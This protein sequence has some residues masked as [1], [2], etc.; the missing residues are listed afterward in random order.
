[1]KKK[2][3][4][5]VILFTNLKIVNGQQA[6]A[7]NG[8]ISDRLTV[9]I[10]VYKMLDNADKEKGDIDGS[11]YFTRRSVKSGLA[12][13]AILSANSHRQCLG[14]G[15]GFTSYNKDNAEI[16]HYFNA[17]INI[18]GGLVGSD[19]AVLAKTK[20]DGSVEEI[21]NYMYGVHVV[22]TFKSKISRVNDGGE[23]GG[24]ELSGSIFAGKNCLPAINVRGEYYWSDNL[25]TGA[26]W[27]NDL[28]VVPIVGFN[29]EQFKFNAGYSPFIHMFSFGLVFDQFNLKQ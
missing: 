7:S 20:A 1:M 13:N 24:Y 14:A 8:T 25:F 12:F 11:I 6:D 2:L 4:L 26:V 29:I 3:F 27:N 21:P 10:A 9:D 17:G 5:L 23:K 19:G 28:G 22:T 15:L 18:V 16:K